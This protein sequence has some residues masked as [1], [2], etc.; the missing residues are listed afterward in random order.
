MKCSSSSCNRETVGRKLCESCHSSN[1]KSNKRRVK[2]LK[3][4]GL[5]I[6]CRKP[7]SALR[8]N[9]C[10][11]KN[12][13]RRLLG[14][15]ELLNDV[16]IMFDQQNGI[17]TYSGLPIVIGVNASLDHKTPKSKGGSNDLENLHWVHSGINRLKGDMNHQDFQKFI[18]EL[19]DSLIRLLE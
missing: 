2:K 6:G 7:A 3:E 4:Q 10:C 11:L 9:I 5:C 8:C 18:I 1:Y 19:K 13:L 16:L 17:C 14:S 15:N 12:S